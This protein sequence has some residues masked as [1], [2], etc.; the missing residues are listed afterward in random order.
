MCRVHVSVCVNFCLYLCGLVYTCKVEC[1]Y[2]CVCVP[3]FAAET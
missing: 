2:V 3:Y 1:V